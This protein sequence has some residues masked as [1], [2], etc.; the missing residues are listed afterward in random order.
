MLGDQ[1][2]GSTG[3]DIPPASG[4]RPIA[5]GR[6]LH[7]NFVCALLNDLFGVQE[8]D[9]QGGAGYRRGNADGL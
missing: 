6:F 5:T 9:G 7:Y 2:Q 1:L 8:R 4:G 3:S